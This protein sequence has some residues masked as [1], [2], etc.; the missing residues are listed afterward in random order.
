MHRAK[1]IYFFLIKKKRDGPKQGVVQ[2]RVPSHIS[3]NF[4]CLE[5]T[6]IVEFKSGLLKSH[7]GY[8]FKNILDY[9][10]KASSTG[11]LN[12]LIS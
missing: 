8:I 11:L 5:M 2:G 3:R 7:L 10:C 9:M 1:N 12:F 6:L 4:Q